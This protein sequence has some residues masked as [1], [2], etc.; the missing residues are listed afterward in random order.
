VESGTTANYPPSEWL[1]AN[2]FGDYPTIADTK[3]EDPAYYAYGAGGLPFIVFL[4][5]DNNVVLRTTGELGDESV[6]TD[7]FDALSKGETPQD[8]RG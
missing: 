8:P 2:G 3:D 1:A 6:Y 4:D 7:I 5:A